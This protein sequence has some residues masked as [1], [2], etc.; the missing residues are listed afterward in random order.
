MGS[1]R[2][3]CGGL[4]VEEE[5]RCTADL[6]PNVSLDEYIL[7]PN[8]LHGII[9]LH[10]RPSPQ[11][12]PVETHRGASLHP[13]RRPPHSLGSIIANFKGAVTR[14]ARANGYPHFAWQRGYYDHIIRDARDLDR[15]RRYIRQNPLKWTLDKYHVEA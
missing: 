6:R 11:T 4:I 7:M 13:L 8:H 14:W 9:I 2:I 3:P 15:I 12:H 1:R 5:W 10:E